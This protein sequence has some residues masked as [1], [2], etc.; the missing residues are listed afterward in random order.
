MNKEDN[1]FIIDGRNKSIL[2][3][4]NNSEKIYQIVEKQI[5]QILNIIYKND[6]N[7][8]FGISLNKC[9]TLFTGYGNIK[10]YFN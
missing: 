5:K 4:E 6:Q 9:G 2:Y 1:T 10:H 7:I 8:N 3:K